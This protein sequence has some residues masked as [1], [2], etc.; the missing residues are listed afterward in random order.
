LAGFYRIAFLDVELH[1]LTGYVGADFDLRLG[2][3]LATGRNGLAD[4]PAFR[5]FSR[6]RFPFGL[7]FI[8]DENDSHEYGHYAK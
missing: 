5:F 3:Y 7:S 4:I 6:H 8:R 2:K 1:D